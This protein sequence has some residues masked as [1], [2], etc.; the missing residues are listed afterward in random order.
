MKTLTYQEFLDEIIP[1][2]EYNRMLSELP[3]LNF[4][5]NL[6]LRYD[7]SEWDI[8]DFNNIN[9]IAGYFI[10]K[11]MPKNWGIYGLDMS[12]KRLSLNYWGDD[13]DDFNIA[14]LELEELTNLFKAK[15]F[16]ILNYKTLKDELHEQA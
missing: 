9:D 10:V 4:N 14:I 16:I 8:G 7:L 2:S 13:N 15:G 3:D 11:N 5:K 12:K 1:E 6:N